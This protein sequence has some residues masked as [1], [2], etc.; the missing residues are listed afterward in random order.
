MPKRNIWVDPKGNRYTRHFLSRVSINKAT[1]TK[2]ALRATED[3]DAYEGGLVWETACLDHATT[4]S[5]ETLTNAR[6]WASRPEWCGPC[7]HIIYCDTDECLSDHYSSCA[8][9]PY[10]LSVTRTDVN[11]DIEIGTRYHYELIKEG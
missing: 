7:H 6:G 3:S 2:I 10:D 4:C 11:D 8:F 5:H 9:D 1:G